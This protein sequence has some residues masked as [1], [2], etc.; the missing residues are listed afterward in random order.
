MSPR[1]L[2]PNGL[3]REVPYLN[4]GDVPVGSPS[5]LNAGGVDLGE[6]GGQISTAQAVNAGAAEDAP[7]IAGAS[8][9][10]RMRRT[11]QPNPAPAPQTGSAPTPRI[12]AGSMPS[13]VPGEQKTALEKLEENINSMDQNPIEAKINRIGQW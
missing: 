8:S 12:R 9:G 5:I 7:A 6:T 1:I 3:T 10:L 4:P 2:L 13:Q 11:T